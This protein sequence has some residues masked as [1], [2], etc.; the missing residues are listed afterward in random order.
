MFWIFLVTL[1]LAFC[2]AKLSP[3][4]FT[5]WAF[6]TQLDLIGDLVSQRKEFKQSLSCSQ[7]WRTR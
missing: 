4:A 6:S 3:I 5:T 2:L 1:R 7:A